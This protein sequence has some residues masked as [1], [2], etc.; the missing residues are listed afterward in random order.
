MASWWQLRGQQLQAW[1]AAPN[2]R[3]W[4]TQLGSHRWLMAGLVFL[5]L[6]VIVLSGLA[7]YWSQFPARPDIRAQAAAA[8][9]SR[10]LEPV[11]GWTTSYA[12][13]Y[14]METLLTKPGGFI[15][16]DIMPP[17]LFMDDMP[18]WEKGVIFMSRDLAR[19]MRRDFSRT[20]S[21]SVDDANLRE[22]EPLFNISMDSWIFPAAESEYRSGLRYLDIY[23]NRLAAPEMTDAQFYA[24]ADNLERWLSDVE[25][26]LGSL[27]LRLSASVGHRQYQS[28]LAGDASAQQSTQSVPQQYLKTPRFQVDDVYFEARGSAWA[29]LNFLRAVEVDFAE[30]LARRNAE[31]TLQQIIIELEA[32]QAR[33]RVPMVMN[34]SGYGLFANHSLVMSGYIARANAGIAELRDLLA[35]G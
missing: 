19:A 27:S 26:R 29:L 14:S 9:E 33:L 6:L 16:N 21:Q 1:L 12:L 7:I 35:R 8:A 4:R 31:Q 18:N 5:A 11:V 15:R 10:G 22:L 17:G 34:G 24:R 13:H 20:Q 28:G 2:L 25:N 32:T 3:Q 30:V 23:M